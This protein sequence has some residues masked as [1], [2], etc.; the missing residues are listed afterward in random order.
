MEELDDT[1]QLEQ[2]TPVPLGKDNKANKSNKTIKKQVKN[3][4]TDELVSC[5][6]N[7]RV[8][9]RFVPSTN[10]LWGNNKKHV[11]Y[12]GMSNNSIRTFVVPR[13]RSG[14]YVNVLTNSEKEFLESYMGLENNA[15]SVYN[16]E[17]TNFWND[18]NPD[19]IGII[20]LRKEDTILDLSNPRDYIKYKILLA[21]KDLICPSM[22]DFEDCPKA[23][24][25][26]VLLQENNDLQQ[27]ASK[28][29]LKMNCYKEFGKIEDN[30]DLLKYIVESINVRPLDD[31][32]KIE[33]LRSE[34]DS[35]ITNNPKAFYDIIKD[36][37]VSTKVMIKQ[38]VQ[39][40]IIV[41]RGNQHYLRDGNMPL[42]GNNEEPT[43]N[44]AAAFLNKS[45]NQALK[46]SIEAKLKQE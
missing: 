10:P 29:S 18:A 37:L 36:P 20:I 3:D 43:L 19:G 7:E 31:N 5:L 38:A 2:G 23:T 6:R 32:I 11:L 41:M 9:V 27:A 33:F 46:F 28:T 4:D 30:Y 8:I 24:Y 15:L 12:G 39:R 40:G 17:K 42:C 14:S 35:I 45:K 16:P 34:V 25:Q 21:N 26:Y 22:K 1:I 13:L 44:I